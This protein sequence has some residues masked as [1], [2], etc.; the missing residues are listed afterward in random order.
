MAKILVVDDSK[1]MRTLVVEALSAAGHSVVEAEDGVEGVNQLKANPDVQLL[2][3]DVNMPRLD[4]ISMCERMKDQNLL[5]TIPVFMLT[6]ESGP[7]MKIRGK[8]L[9]VRAWMT[10]PFV[11]SKMVE[12]V[13][14]VLKV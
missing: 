10:K 1:T 13:Q 9:G 12:A 2:I 3:A 11:A 14:K 4:G 8:D 6:T 5:G 7:E